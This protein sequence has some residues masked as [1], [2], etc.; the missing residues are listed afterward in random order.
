MDDLQKQ[1]IELEIQEKELEAAEFVGSFSNAK[2][3]TLII[4]TLLIIPGYFL[5]K[6]A[7]AQILLY[8][9]DKSK[10]TA[11]PA[12]VTSLPIEVVKGQSKLLPVTDTNYS[13][14]ALIQNPNRD[15]VATDVSYTFRFLDE[16]GKVLHSV[17]E[18]TSLLPGARKYLIVPNVRINKT[19]NS[20][21]VEFGDIQWK[22]RLSITEVVLQ[23]SIPQFG[24]QSSPLGFFVEGTIR[25]NSVYNL[26]SILI[27]GIVRDSEG[28]I[29]A[30]SQYKADAVTT[31]ESR[32]YRL[33]WPL[34]IADKVTNTPEIIVETNVLDPNNLLP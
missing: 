2:R 20:V 28:E 6:F 14:Y 1:K 5:A 12:V 16:N 26:R 4:L 11:H 27:S 7:T 13:A 30:V 24:R 32:E 29:I 34:D 17:S 31:K 8:Q 18:K 9:F 22:K 33:F 10:V 15:L 21:K 23:K 19:P 25:N 3:V